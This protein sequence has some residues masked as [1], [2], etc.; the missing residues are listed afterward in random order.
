MN[1]SA[2]ERSL[3]GSLLNRLMTDV[4][5]VQAFFA[6]AINATP[7]LFKVIGVVLIMLSIHPGL[8]G[9]LL[10]IVPPM[11]AA[12]VA[13][14]KLD[15]KWLREARRRV[16][17]MGGRFSEWLDGLP[18]IR[19]YNRQA[20]TSARM[21]RIL[22]DVSEASVNSE[23][24]VRL[25]E[26]LLFLCYGSGTFLVYLVGTSRL[27]GESISAGT[28]IAFVAYMGM[29]WDP[30]NAASQL[31]HSYH[32]A[33][34]AARRVREVLDA[35]ADAR[36]AETLAPPTIHGRLSFD[37]VEYRYPDGEFSVK[38]CAFAIEPGERVALV[39][40]TGS[41]KS[42]LAALI[43]G[44]FRPTAG[45]IR[46]D[47]YPLDRLTPAYRAEKIA[48]VAQDSYLFEGTI[49]DNLTFSTPTATDEKLRAALEAV[50]PGMA[51]ETEV[52]EGGANLSGGQRQAVSIARALLTDAR[53]VIFDEATANINELSE[54][55]MT[56]RVY[57]LTEGRTVITIAHRKSTILR[58]SRAL[59]MRAG[60]LRET[61]VQEALDALAEG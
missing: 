29:F 5:Q 3:K 53:I 61:S 50:A 22:S 12:R 35:E 28:F 48:I 20:D 13:V 26:L 11:V 18:V 57:A 4:D 38:P 55:D 17:E 47:E 56:R 25:S 43:T 1:L 32:Q 41:G 34:V 10:L 7:N 40:A 45:T 46:V 52:R 59:F 54:S 33:L 16:E 15:K 42:T 9:Y 27:S 39:G 37:A 49:R 44:L 36:A 31:Y 24:A 14:S 23:I 58:Q 21:R 6:D 51:L 30:V 8:T 2:L 60:E 19:A